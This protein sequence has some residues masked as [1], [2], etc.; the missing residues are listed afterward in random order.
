MTS[1]IAKEWSYYDLADWQIMLSFIL[2]LLI[3]QSVHRIRSD[4]YMTLLKTKVQEY[5][6]EYEYEYE[7]EYEYEYKYK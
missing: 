2:K 6:Y 4:E 1:L 5:I 7:C 3:C